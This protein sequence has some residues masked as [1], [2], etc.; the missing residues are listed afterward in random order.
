M[1][2]EPNVYVH[3]YTKKED[4]TGPCPHCDATKA[5]LSERNIPFSF[6]ELDREERKALYANLAKVENPP[7]T[8]N[9][10]PQIVLKDND[11]QI[12]HY[13]GGNSDLV[14]SGLNSLFNP[15]KEKVLPE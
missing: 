3:V 1:T 11:E 5:W 14:G 7:P 13:L 9:S 10:V 6:Q 2:T 8:N 15:N 12:V 4:E